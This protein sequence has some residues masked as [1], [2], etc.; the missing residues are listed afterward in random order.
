[1]AVYV[2]R[3]R[4]AGVQMQRQVSEIDRLNRQMQS[5]Q[6]AILR[7][8]EELETIRRDAESV[9]V[10]TAVGDGVPQGNALQLRL[11]L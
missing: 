9:P 3:A 1:M 2:V 6:A 7:L 10:A 5:A 4:K 8:Q 11:R